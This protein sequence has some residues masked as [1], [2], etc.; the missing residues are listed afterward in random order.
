MGIEQVTE[1]GIEIKKTSFEKSWKLVY[2]NITK[3]IILL[4][5]FPGITKT[6]KDIYMS[7][8]FKD[9]VNHILTNSLNYHSIVIKDY[10]YFHTE[11]MKD[12]TSP[13]N[14]DIINLIESFHPDNWSLVYENNEVVNL[15]Q[16]KIKIPATQSVFTS[17]NIED[18][19]DKITEL[20]LSFPQQ[21]DYEDMY[22]EYFGLE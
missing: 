13:T 14:D 21:S 3:E 4:N 6:K 19:F 18:C 5:K 1:N 7:T 11:A 8:D 10:E 9:V 15:T 2:D 12:L 20:E 17:I 16:E 22:P